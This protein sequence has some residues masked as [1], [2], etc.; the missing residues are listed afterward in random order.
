MN[1]QFLARVRKTS[2][3]WW[4]TG[5]LTNG[6]GTFLVG[7]KPWRA[8]RYSYL[9]HVGEIPTGAL[10]HHKC[11]NTACVR[12]SH[13]QALSP[14]E[15]SRYHFPKITHCKRGHEFTAENTRMT[16]VGTRACRCCHRIH[17]TSSYRRNNPSVVCGFPTPRPCRKITRH[18]SGRCDFHRKSCPMKK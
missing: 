14:G 8:H 7:G 15:H 9:L 17:S 13:L 6:Y 16:K 12:P 11:E 10:V 2:G 5:G 18:P 1:D 3:C 4:W